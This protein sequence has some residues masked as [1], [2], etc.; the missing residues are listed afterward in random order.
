M[1]FP[2][3]LLSHPCFF[4][5]ISSLYLLS[6]NPLAELMFD[7]I[8]ENIANL[9]K[10]STGFIGRTFSSALFLRLLG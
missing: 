10:G 9:A 3:L 7:N 2:T 1:R 6:L 4:M 5:A 8:S